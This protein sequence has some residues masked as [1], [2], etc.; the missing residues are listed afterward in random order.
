M[1]EWEKARE[2]FG[3]LA[4]ACAEASAA[5]AAWVSATVKGLC[6]TLDVAAIIEM[7]AYATVNKEHP[8]WVHR[9]LYSKKKRIRKKYHD[10]IMRK[11]GRA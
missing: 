7:A 8:E 6:E 9:A 11:Y 4:D 10:R 1:S 2:A 3:K 5:I